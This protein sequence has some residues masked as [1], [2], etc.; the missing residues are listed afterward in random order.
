[1][2]ANDAPNF[3]HAL[4]RK[5]FR[6][7]SGR[8][9]EARRRTPH[10]ASCHAVAAKRVGG[11]AIPNSLSAPLRLRASPIPHFSSCHALA[12]KRV[13][14]FPLAPDKCSLRAASPNHSP[15][16]PCYENVTFFP[17]RYFDSSLKKGLSTQPN[18]EKT[19]NTQADFTPVHAVTRCAAYRHQHGFQFYG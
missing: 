2:S 1:M 18:N 15:H 19:N 7:L 17:L 9:R 10:S 14:G 5:K 3:I 6:I 8:S 4:L 16:L 12:A 11:S 13:G